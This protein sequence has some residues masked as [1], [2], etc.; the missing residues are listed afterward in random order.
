MINIIK[1]FI[2]IIGLATSQF[3][4]TVKFPHRQ[5]YISKWISDEHRSSIYNV[6]EQLDLTETEN[7]TGN[8]IRIEYANYN[9]GGTEMLAYSHTDGYF[10]VYQ[11]V[12]G[13]NRLLND[14]MFQCIVLH[15]ICHSMGLGHTSEGVMSPVINYTENYC[16]LSIE[17]Y[18]N[19]FN[20]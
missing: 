7:K 20:V 11:T 13:I 2:G 17:N 12:I 16:Y 9:G 14:V 15:E 19:L 8:Y 18:I 4:N 3:I 5:V 6:I 10:E 1:T